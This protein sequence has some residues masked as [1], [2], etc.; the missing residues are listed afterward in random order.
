M[1][2]PTPVPIILFTC[3]HL[4]DLSRASI[5]K[6][7][8]PC[9][10]QLSWSG[11]GSDMKYRNT[12]APLMGCSFCRGR[13]RGVL[14]PPPEEL[15]LGRSLALCPTGEGGH[16]G[17]GLART[18]TL[19]RP[20]RGPKSCALAEKGGPRATNSIG[21]DRQPSVQSSVEVLGTSAGILQFQW[22]SRPSGS[23][24]SF[25]AYMSRLV[26]HPKRF[27][28]LRVSPPPHPKIATFEKHTDYRDLSAS[29]LCLRMGGSECS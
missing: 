3:S 19:W 26:E 17:R 11:R 6:P 1:R 18:A 13:P 22:A 16:R 9:A 5:R 2:Y 20:R 28:T 10:N 14:K 24:Q 29:F 15:L 8:L 21:F 25:S 23:S 4:K 7:I 12:W 27:F